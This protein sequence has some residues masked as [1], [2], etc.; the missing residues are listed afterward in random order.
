MSMNN[1][2]QSVIYATV[3]RLYKERAEKKLFPYVAIENDIKREI[4]IAVSEALTEMVADGVLQK[5]ENVNGHR[6]FA[7]VNV[8][9]ITNNDI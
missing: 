6:M 1:G 5:T 8:G 2:L 4:G 7:P 9:M 3:R